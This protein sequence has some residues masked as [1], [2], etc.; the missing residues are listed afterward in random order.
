MIEKNI[1]DHII[2]GRI[3]AQRK[4]FNANTV[5][6]DKDLAI[7]NNLITPNKP[8]FLYGLKVKYQENLAKDLGFN[9]L[10]CQDNSTEDRIHKLEARMDELIVLKNMLISYIKTFG[11]PEDFNRFLDNN[12]TYEDIQILLKELREE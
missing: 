9:F 11:E 12:F 5:V 3:E 1:L 6:I 4:L 2:K 8:M 10:L 7:T